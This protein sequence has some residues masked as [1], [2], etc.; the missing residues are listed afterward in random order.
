MYETKIKAASGALAFASLIT[1]PALAA[2]PAGAE[3]ARTTAPS[4]AA[5]A[6]R[7]TSYAPRYY[8]YGTTG[9]WAYFEAL[10]ADNCVI[11]VKVLCDYPDGTRHWQY[12]EWVDD[13]GVSNM[14]D[15]GFGGH[16]VGNA[17]YEV[18]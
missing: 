8:N 12:G 7:C 11:R 17:G 2:A 18:K 5:A 15:C 14:F 13:T 4:A 6:P 9:G 16:R 1:A 10:G 3:A